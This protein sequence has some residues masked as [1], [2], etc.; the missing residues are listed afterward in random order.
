MTGTGIITL[1]LIIANCIFSYKGLK[2]N[3]FFERYKFEVEKITIYRQYERI[4]SSGFLHVSWMHLI[5]N[6]LSLYFFSGGVES[7]L[8]GAEY[9]LIY[10]AS[11]IGGNLF[12]LLIHKNQGDYSSVGASGA[13]CGVIFASIALFPGFVIRLF[14][15]PIGIP[16]W[17]YGLVFVLY[18]I[19]G[20]RSRRD[21]VGHEAHLGGALI[22][23]AV[24]VILEPSALTTNLFAIAVIAL[25]CIFFIY[26]IITRPGFLLIDN[27]F[28]KA[29]N[30]NYTIDQRYNAEKADKQ[31]EV[32]RI[33]EKISRSGMNSLTKKERQEL[34][35]YSERIK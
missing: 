13:V 17:L 16:A 15:I 9:L 22:G 25:P 8:G 23:M 31:K 3:A 7:Y 19:Y 18:S 2:D 14:F 27:N 12:S 5:F 33:L 32:D 34:N 1:I 20:I 11:L 24:A 4:I 21:N 6:M 26:M 35:D 29:H 30:K 28:F 10:F